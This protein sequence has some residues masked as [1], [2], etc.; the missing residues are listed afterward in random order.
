MHK[1][2]NKIKVVNVD[3]QLYLI[4]HSSIECASYVI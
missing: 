2:L 1:E 4:Y 3:V